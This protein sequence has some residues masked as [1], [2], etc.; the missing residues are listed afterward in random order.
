MDIIFNKDFNDDEVV[1]KFEAWAREEHAKRQMKKNRLFSLTYSDG[2]IEFG[3]FQ[4]MSGSMPPLW[5]GHNAWED[6]E[7][8]YKNT[9]FKCI[10]ILYR[11]CEEEGT[12]VME[13]P[14]GGIAKKLI[15]CRK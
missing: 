3:N 14:T 4:L 7:Q 2:S 15:I 5:M 6:L 13:T 11:V 1:A 9:V 8:K 10:E 12:T